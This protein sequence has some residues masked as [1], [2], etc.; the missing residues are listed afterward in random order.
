MTHYRKN[1]YQD[2]YSFEK[3]SSQH[4]RRQQGCPTP[5]GRT[6]VKKNNSQNHDNGKEND[7]RQK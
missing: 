3:R 6:M 7:S 5:K 2:R 4:E 1:E